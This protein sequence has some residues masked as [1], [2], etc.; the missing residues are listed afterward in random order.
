MVET[1]VINF[2]AQPVWRR[3][4]RYDYA[5]NAMETFDYDA[6]IRMKAVLDKDMADCV[7]CQK[8]PKGSFSPDHATSTAMLE[9]RV[10]GYTYHCR[11]FSR[12]YNP[13]TG[14]MEGHAHCTCDGCF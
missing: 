14:A 1:P 12:W 11:S 6:V 3:K 4:F 7:T 10:W 8:Y 2:P 13:V 9:P 5:S